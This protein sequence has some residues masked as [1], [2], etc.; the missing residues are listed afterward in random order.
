M[1]LQVCL[2]LERLPGSEVVY[3]WHRMGSQG[4]GRVAGTG[5]RS[6]GKEEAAAAS[7]D[8]PPRKRIKALC[9]PSAKALAACDR[10]SGERWVGGEIERDPLMVS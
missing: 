3:T 8:A 9:D 7:P 6:S 1:R 5:S 10:N 2:C 4:E